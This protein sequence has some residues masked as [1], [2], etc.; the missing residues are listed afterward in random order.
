[1]VIAYFDEGNTEVTVENWAL[2]LHNYCAA[3]PFDPLLH[4]TLFEEQQR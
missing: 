4:L 2:W 1:L 3:E